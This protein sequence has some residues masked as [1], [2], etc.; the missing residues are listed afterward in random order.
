MQETKEIITGLARYSVEKAVKDKSIPALP[1]WV[2]RGLLEKKAGVFVSLHRGKDLRG[3]MGSLVP[4][5]ENL[6][7]EIM[8]L[9]VTAAQRD[10]RFPPVSP[11]ELDQLTYSVDVL[12]EAEDIGDK[13]DLDPERY[14]L[15]VSLGYKKGVLLPRLDG[16]DKIED[17]LFIA[18]N[19]AGIRPNQPYQMARFEVVRYQEEEERS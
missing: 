17:Q 7:Q 13:K 5:R 10:P 4:S 2:D 14:G 6:A 12:G 16:I 8:D 1:D 19:K 15:I 9:A 18:L 11:H 3:C